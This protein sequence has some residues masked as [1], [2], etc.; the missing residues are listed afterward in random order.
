MDQP[1]ARTELLLGPERL[2]QLQAS[3]VAVFGLGGVGGYVVEGLARCGIGRF[4]LVDHDHVA[5]TNLN[6]QLLATRLTIG[7]PKVEVARERILLINPAAE[8]D[9]RQVRYQPGL[10]D[11]LLADDLD[12]LVDAIDTISAKL[13]L[14]VEAQRRGIRLIS[15]MG[16][17]NKLDPTRFEVADLYATT[18]CPLARL[19]R[20][21]LRPRGVTALK[22]VYSR[23]PPLP[24]DGS[25]PPLPG[26]ETDTD[27]TAEVEPS[28]VRRALPG[29]IS[30]VPAVVGMILAGEV[31]RD[32]VGLS[33]ELPVPGHPA[34]EETEADGPDT[35]A[36]A[37]E[38]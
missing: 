11:T 33:R 23:E 3:R 21:K 37:G 26:N 34:A 8:V 13:D 31:V 20:K 6:R 15:A 29:S 24:V 14:I 22:V 25:R 7:R 28:G 30:F 9:C 36:A 2:R 1:F 18:V 5:E 32:L 16:A 10:A 4:L 38:R 12:Y 27:A 35:P 17:G 19:L